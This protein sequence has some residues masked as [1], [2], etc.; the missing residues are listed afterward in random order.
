MYNKDCT[1]YKMYTNIVHCIQMYTK[2]FA[3]YSNVYQ[4]LYIEHQ[5]QHQQIYNTHAPAR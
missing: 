2:H 5:A 3:L 4:A 1:L